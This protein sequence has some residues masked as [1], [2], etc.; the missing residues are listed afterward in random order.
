MHNTPIIL[1]NPFSYFDTDVRTA[2]GSDGLIWFC[3]KDI[4][5]ILEITNS[6]DAVKNLEA[7]ERDTVANT[8]G[9]GRKKDMIFVSESGLY[10]LIFNSRKPE[11][12]KFRKWVTAD[13]LPMIRKNGYFGQLTL[14][15]QIAGSNLVMALLRDLRKTKKVYDRQ[16]ILKR[17]TNISNS[18]GEA[19]PDISLIDTEI[20]QFE[21]PLTA[22]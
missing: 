7:D 8:D 22:G 20:D 1:S 6:R 13:V 15:D 16:I 3:A 18:L 19:L 5:D 12:K 11:A 2:V 21:L 4:C 9:V 17:L 14:K 10:A